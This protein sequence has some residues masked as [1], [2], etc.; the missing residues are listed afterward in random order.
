MVEEKC[1]PYIHIGI[2]YSLILHESVSRT[3]SRDETLSLGSATTL[4][5]VAKKN[6]GTGKLTPQSSL[7]SVSKHKNNSM[8]LMLYTLNWHDNLHKKLVSLILR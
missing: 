5:V 6:A 4:R 2:T 7:R 8:L 3:L 1:A